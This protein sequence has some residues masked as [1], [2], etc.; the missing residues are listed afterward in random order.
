ML[1]N[2]CGGVGSHRLGFGLRGCDDGFDRRVDGRHGG[3]RAEW[4]ERRV[5]KLLLESLDF[6]VGLAVDLVEAA[7]GMP[8]QLR[9]LLNGVRQFAVEVRL[10]DHRLGRAVASLAHCFDH[11]PGVG[12][13]EGVGGA[14][15]RRGRRVQIKALFTQRARGV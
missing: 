10:V 8:D 1:P 7:A 9:S 11:A 12:A 5:L 6:L 15:D 13:A 3:A 14:T 4:G 2:G